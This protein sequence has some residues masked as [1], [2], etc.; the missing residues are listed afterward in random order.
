MVH[1]IKKK[2][3]VASNNPVKIKAATEGFCRMFPENE[4]EVSGE[5]IPSGVSDQPRSDDE[6]FRGAMNRTESAARKIP[7]ADFWVGLE[8]GIEEKNREM[9]AFAWAVVK[10]R[11]GKIGKGR[12]GTFF[13]PEKVALLIRQGKELGEADDIVFSRKNSKHGS[14]SIGLLTNDAIDRTKY[15]VDAVIF[16]LIPFRNPD[17]Y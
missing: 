3:I 2:I 10:S 1:K 8:G 17:L 16:A 6:S 4:F 15:Y 14:G 11:D 9:E 5:S 13:L 12:T 7:A